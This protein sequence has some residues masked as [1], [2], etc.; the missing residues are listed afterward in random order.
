[1]KRR[2]FTSGPTRF[3]RDRFVQIA[4]EMESAAAA[5]APAKAF[6]GLRLR[7]PSGPAARVRARP[8]SL[9]TA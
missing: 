2:H 7:V 9:A 6:Q 5:K 3:W 4:R 1:M 8:S